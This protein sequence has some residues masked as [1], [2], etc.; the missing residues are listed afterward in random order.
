MYTFAARPADFSLIWCK[1]YEVDVAKGRVMWMEDLCELRNKD[2]E[3][4]VE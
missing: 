2:I 1:C 3:N 4:I